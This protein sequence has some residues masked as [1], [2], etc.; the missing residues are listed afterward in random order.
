[1]CDGVRN[2]ATYLYACIRNE[3]KKYFRIKTYQKR[4]GDVIS[5]N[6]I[7][8]DTGDEILELLKTD[9]DLEQEAILNERKEIVIKILSEIKKGDYY[10]RLYGINCKK[11]SVKEIAQKENCSTRNIYRQLYI[12][13][14]EFIEKWR[15]YYGEI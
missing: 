14:K 15:K 5:L 11:E 10:K 12:A 6:K 13:K 8:E 7:I 2:L 4:N 1:M 9:E 3:I